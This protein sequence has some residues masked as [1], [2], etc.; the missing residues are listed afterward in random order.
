MIYLDNAATSYPKPRA[1]YSAVSRG[2]RRYGGNPGRGSHSL[3]RAASDA[4]Y[5]LRETAGRFFSC[6]PERVV[7]CSNATHALNLAIFGLVK[8]PCHILM[9]DIE[10]NS[11]RRPVLSLCRSMGCSCSVFKSC[12]GDREAVLGAISRQLRE[13][14]R[15]VVVNHVSNVCGVT[16]PVKAICR[17]CKKLGI[18]VVIDASQS[19]GHLPIDVS[20][21]G[22]DAVCM[23]GHK[24]LY[25]P[26]G[27]GL[28]LLGDGVELSPL[29]YGGSG[30]DSLSE[31]MPDAYPERLEAGTLAAP[32]AAGL[33][34]GIRFIERVSPRVIRE[35]ECRLAHLTAEYL[36]DMGHVKLYGAPFENCGST[37]LFNVDGYTPAQ[38][39]TV[40]DGAGICVRSG[41]HCAPLA[42]RTL[43]TGENGAVR[44]SFG[45]FNTVIDVRRLADEVYMLAKGTR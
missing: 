37:V 15:L 26:A 16:L 3:A 12:V 32:L 17:F 11:T 4:I 43:G 13:D 31:E 10:H 20:T 40:L 36:A 35:H 2:L 18:K 34:E 44:S 1:V 14:T 33:A 19:A 5:D 29:L 38:V 45:Y 22:A 41:L 30:M 24:G 28:L 6:D 21:L 25:G 27:T 23:P 9:S 8:G 7:F 42:H 39:G